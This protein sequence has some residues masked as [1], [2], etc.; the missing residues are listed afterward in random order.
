MKNHLINSLIKVDILYLKEKWKAKTHY[1]KRISEEGKSLTE[2]LNALAIKL[3]SQITDEG[4]KQ[5][6]KVS[7]E[8]VLSPAFVEYSGDFLAAIYETNSS[9]HCLF[10]ALYDDEANKMIVYQKDISASEFQKIYQSLSSHPMMVIPKSASGLDGTYH[11][12]RIGGGANA[13]EFQ[14][15]SDSSGDQWS[16]VYKMREQL[17]DLVKKTI[18]T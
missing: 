8:I 13:V 7:K 3:D 15:W 18:D 14:W 17:Q 2:V 11:N 5:I 16:L 4:L 1:I 10:Y 12:L 6:K 9:S